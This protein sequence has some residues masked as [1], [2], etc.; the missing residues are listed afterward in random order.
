MATL[1]AATNCSDSVDWL[2]SSMGGLIGMQLAAVPNSPIRKLV[3]N[4]IGNE[5]IFST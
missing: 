4:D 2:G 1:L 5:I 3:L